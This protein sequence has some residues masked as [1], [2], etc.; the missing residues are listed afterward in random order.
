MGYYRRF[1]KGY[2][3]ITWPLTEMSKQDSFHWTPNTKWAFQQLKDASTTIPTLA[4]PDFTQQFTVESNA[5]TYGI[6][7]ILSQE[8]HPLA[9]FSKKLSSRMSKASTYVRELYAITQVVA[10]WRHYLLGNKFVIKTYH[11]SLKELM[12]Q[13]IQ[14]LEQQ[15]YLTKLL[16]YEFDIVYKVGK[17]KA[18]VD[19][20][21]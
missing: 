17:H 21:S 1:V 14:T 4:L 18:V 7:A 16:G 11:K 20:L 5:S 2:A 12:A 13:V 6:R 10:R 19:A 9:Y 15:Y 3:H 8:G